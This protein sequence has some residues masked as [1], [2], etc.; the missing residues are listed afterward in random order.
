MANSFK[1]LFPHGISNALVIA[2]RNQ[3]KIKEYSRILGVKVIG[4]DLKV[5]EIQSEDPLVV[6]T[7]KAKAAWESNDGESI[8]VEDSAL[9]CKG[10]DGLPGPFADQF[11]NTLRKRQALCRMLDGYDRSAV[12]QVGIAIYDGSEAYHRL[13]RISG[14]IADEPI[15]TEGFGFDDIFIPNGQRNGRGRPSTKDSA[16]SYAQMS[17]KI[18]DKFSPRL[19]AL[20]KLLR[21]PFVFG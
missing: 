12:F 16:K 5:L 19:I 7:E 1:R 20:K 2:S 17:P 15:G 6:L 4:K 13:G 8:M 21:K 18:K 11:T 9:I 14:M 10:L 3:E